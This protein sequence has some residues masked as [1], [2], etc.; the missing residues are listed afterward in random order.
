M[1][2]SAIVRQIQSAWWVR[3]DTYCEYPRVGPDIQYPIAYSYFVLNRNC[4]RDTWLSKTYNSVILHGQRSQYWRTWLWK[5]NKVTRLHWLEVLV[6]E[7]VQQFSCWSGFTMFSKDK[8]Y[9]WIIWRI[10]KHHIQGRIYHGANGAAAP[11]P[12]HNRGLHQKDRK[13][14]VHFMNMLF[15]RPNF[16]WNL[17]TSKHI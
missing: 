12:H 11:G 14:H 10:T 17:N 6:V 9:V 5:F 2:K 1:C 7:R 16:E 13:G 4:A 15:F 8:L 3:W